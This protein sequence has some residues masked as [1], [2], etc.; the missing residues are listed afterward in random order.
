M[1]EYHRNEFELLITD[2]K[3][4][5]FNGILLN[6]KLEVYDDERLNSELLVLLLKF[7]TNKLRSVQYDQ[8]LAF[9]EKA[10]MLR[11]IKDNIYQLKL[12]K[13]VSYNL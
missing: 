8:T 2:I 7:Y 11:K 9:R 12:G 3:N 1:F 13:L 6:D 4:Q 10:T 5:S